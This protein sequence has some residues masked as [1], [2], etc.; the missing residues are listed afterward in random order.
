[1]RF[2]VNI[3]TYNQL[4]YL[5][6]V[7]EALEQQ[8]FKDFEVIVCDD[9]SSDGTREWM[10]ENN[11][12]VKYFWQEDKGFRIAKSKNNGIR[13]AE[14]EYFLSLE[15]DVIPHP[16]L[17]KVYNF[18]AKLNPDTVL[19]GVRHDIDGLP[20]ELDWDLMHKSIVA[21]DFRLPDFRLW[22]RLVK[23][24][25]SVSGCNVLFPTQTLR[26]IGGWNEEY[27]HYGVDDWEVALRMVMKGCKIQPVPEA[28]GYH[29][30]HDL[31]ESTDINLEMLK[32]LEE[33]YES[34]N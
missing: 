21:K 10:E 20:E 9:G 2:T 6:K 5:K 3:A 30:K 23:P 22:D 7:L 12:D 17:L 14:G 11:P 26:D 34:S 1:M 4:T 28:F 25:R 13:A 15:A 18:W 19:L 16:T 32:A 29:I 24:W 31:R 27:K 8:E 33:R